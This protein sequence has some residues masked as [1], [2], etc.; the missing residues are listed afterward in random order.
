MIALMAVTRQFRMPAGQFVAAM[1]RSRYSGSRCFRM[2]LLL[3]AVAIVALIAA[4]VIADIRWMIVALMLLFLITPMLLALLYI[5]EAMRPL[6]FFNTLP[7]TVAVEKAD[8]PI[9]VRILLPEKTKGGDDSVSSAEESENSVTE[10]VIRIER[11]AVRPY[12]AG[13]SSVMIPLQSQQERGW[14][15][16]PSSAF[17]DAGA[18]ADFVKSLY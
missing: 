15:W 11:S 12:T 17:D 8:G 6:V 1:F 4:G 9:T 7:H 18:F 5:S 3:V 13:M 16:L 14:L 2:I 10:R